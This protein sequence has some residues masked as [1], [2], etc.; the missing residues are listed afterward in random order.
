MPFNEEIL[1]PSSTSS[2]SSS[3]P[4]AKAGNSFQQSRRNAI[5]NRSVS[6]IKCVP[7]WSR[8]FAPTVIKTGDREADRLVWSCCVCTLSNRSC[9]SILR[10]R[11]G[12]CCRLPHG[13]G[14]IRG[15]WWWWRY[16]WGRRRLGSSSVTCAN[17]SLPLPT[18]EE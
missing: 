7:I 17:S 14:R 3:S 11:C 5:G 2:S 9:Y 4:N 16:Y 12:G 1:H 13:I 8:F 10:S 15:R 6:R 18:I